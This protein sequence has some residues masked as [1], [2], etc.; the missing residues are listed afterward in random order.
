MIEFNVRETMEQIHI[1]EQMQE[2][3]IMDVINRQ[4]RNGKNKARSWKKIAVSAVVVTLTAGIVSLP[5]RAVVNNIVKER[6]ESM[7]QEEVQAINDMVQ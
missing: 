4:M 5:V 2:E 7:P 3:I 1:S 6:M